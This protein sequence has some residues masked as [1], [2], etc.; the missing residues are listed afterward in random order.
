[1]FNIVLFGDKMFITMAYY[2]KNSKNKLEEKDF[3]FLASKE[4]HNNTKY[5]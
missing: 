2:F 3:N 4:E 5:I 1:M